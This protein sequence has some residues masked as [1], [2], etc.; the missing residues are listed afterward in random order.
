MAVKFVPSEDMV[1]DVNIN[2]LSV[3]NFLP[4]QELL[5]TQ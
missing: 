3:Q 2:N 4:L 1:A 5:G